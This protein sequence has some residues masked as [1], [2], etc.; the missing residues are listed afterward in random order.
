TSAST[1]CRFCTTWHPE[2]DRAVLAQYATATH[3]RHQM[4]TNVFLGAIRASAE[5]RILESLKN[6][7]A[8]QD[9]EKDM[10]ILKNIQALYHKDIEFRNTHRNASREA[11]N[12]HVERCAGLPEVDFIRTDITNDPGAD[13]LHPD[14]FLEFDE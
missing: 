8:L 13:G 7:K 1:L 9:L 5:C 2:P 4:E 14:E 6:G 11:Y 3:V 10:R 12:S